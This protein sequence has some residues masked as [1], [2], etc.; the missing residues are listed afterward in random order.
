VARKRA[1]ILVS[2]LVQ[3]VFFRANA[4]RVAD[5]LGLS[6]WIRNLADGRVEALVE[7]EEGAVEQFIS[8]CRRGP[9]SARVEDV[10]VTYERPT[11]DM[12][13]FLIVG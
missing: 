4:K 5:R 3:G 1:H 10:S 2:G 9:P 13:G 7:G 6:G 8:W 12:K 11:G